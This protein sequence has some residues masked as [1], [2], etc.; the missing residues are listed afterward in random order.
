MKPNNLLARAAVLALAANMILPLAAA[1]QTNE[2]RRAGAACP[3]FCALLTREGANRPSQL[4]AGREQKLGEKRA[5]RDQRMAQRRSQHE[6][7]L[8]ELRA[9]NDAKRA[10]RV[11]SLLDKAQADAQKQAVAAFQA[12]LDA[13]MN[14]R[15]AA[16]DQAQ[17]DFKSGIDAAI[18]AR[19]SAADAAVKAFQDALA[20]AE[21]KAKA[22][23]AAAGVDS[24]A[25]R[26]ALRVAV[27]S[28]RAQLR[29]ALLAAEKVGPQVSE[30]TKT[31]NEAVRKAMETFKAAA[32][33]ARTAL[34]TAFAASNP[35]ADESTNEPAE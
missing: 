8:A 24:A 10:D 12:A 22:D 2:P 17:Q 26:E 23:C 35:A 16:V 4:L 6:T 34:K 5:E 11:G 14:A 25:I 29:T 21:A 31:R 32:E 19:K 28:A 3:G 15:R 30:L 33:T 18:A 13:A 27:E 7:R 20:A 1:A 9:A